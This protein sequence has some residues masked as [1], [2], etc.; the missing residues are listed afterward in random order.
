MTDTDN[1][2]DLAIPANTPS[3]AE[4]QLYSLEQAAGGIGLFVN[5]NE[6][7]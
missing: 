4:S 5:T 1:A 7:E 3:Q 2:D 6:T